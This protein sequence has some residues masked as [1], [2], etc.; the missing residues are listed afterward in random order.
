VHN[1]PLSVAAI[2]N[3]RHSSRSHD[4]VIRVYD[5]A[6]NMIE[7]HERRGDFKEP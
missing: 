3:A 7:T 6:E 2:G 1:E 5:A 4:T